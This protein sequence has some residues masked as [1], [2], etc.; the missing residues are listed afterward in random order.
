MR[1]IWSGLK[2]GNDLKLNVKLCVC[3]CVAVATHNRSEMKVFIVSYEISHNS[4]IIQMI[5]ETR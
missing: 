4:H 2:V 5:C 3:L 1:S